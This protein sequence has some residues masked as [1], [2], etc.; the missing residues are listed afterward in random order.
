MIGKKDH[1]S[2]PLKKGEPAKSFRLF[3]S[4]EIDPFLLRPSF[5]RWVINIILALI[6]ALLFQY[7]SGETQSVVTF[8]VGD[9]A[10]EDIYAPADMTLLD[11][12]TTSLRRKQAEESAWPVFDYDPGLGK[13]IETRVHN[14]FSDLRALYQ[15]ELDWN[16]AERNRV[17]ILRKEFNQRR[18]KA[19]PYI[20]DDKFSEREKDLRISLVTVLKGIGPAEITLNDKQFA[21]LK[22]DHFNEE[23]ETKILTLVTQVMNEGVLLS[24]D[25]L[26]KSA[27]KGITVHVMPFKDPSRDEYPKGDIS[28]LRD[29]AEARKNIGERASAEWGRELPKALRAVNV[30]IAQQIVLPNYTFNPEASTV[31]IQTAQ[32]GIEPVY[33]HV[34]KGEKIVGQGEVIDPTVARKLQLISGKTTAAAPGILA[35]LGNFLWIAAL[36]AVLYTFPAHTIRKFN[37]TIKDIIHL[38]I[39]LILLLGILKLVAASF[40][41]IEAPPRFEIAYLIPLVAGAMMIRLLINSEV[42]VIFSVGLSVLAGMMVKDPSMSLFVLVGS[43]VGAN[44]V[45]QARTRTQIVRAGAVTGMASVFMVLVLS[46]KVGHFLEPANALNVLAAF[47]G[48]VLASFLVM[49]LMPVIENIFGYVTDIR[50]L[51]LANQE[52]PLLKALIMNAPGTYQHSLMVGTLAEAAA[53]AIHVNPL[54]VKVAALYHDV[55]K[56]EKPVYFVENQRDGINR[57]DKL[58]PSMSSLIIKSHVMYGVELA[59]MYRLPQPIID[60]IPQHHGTSLIKYFYARAKEREDPELQHIEETDFKYPG[61]KP[62]TREAGILMLADSVEATARSLPDPTPA[63][64]KGMVRRIIGGIFNDGQLDECELTLKDLNAISE[65]FTDVLASIYHSRPEYPSTPPGS[66]QKRPGHQN[67]G[68]KDGDR[69]TPGEQ[70]FSLGEEPPEED[71]KPARKNSIRSPV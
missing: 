23:T 62:Q 21:A 61:P 5:Q 29:L 27:G 64:L 68:K 28:S 58:T 17:E 45:G 2:L 30:E 25:V 65:A 19:I 1:P 69:H 18:V 11:Q 35:F 37:P 16:E 7:P 67:G 47:M 71:P 46:L 48:G 51:E 12:E 24:K 4:L 14:V 9:I 52:H 44:E 43:L 33:F 8:R 54:L 42:A 36:L 3:G 32:K 49:G 41:N 31:R 39:L 20:Y 56:M 66:G 15:P 34:K 70:D 10:Q 26:P 55:G 13:L 63:K 53:E 22:Q 38:S 57:H 6:L 59:K 60:S 50:L 40:T